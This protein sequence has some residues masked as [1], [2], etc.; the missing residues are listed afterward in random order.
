MTKSLKA[1]GAAAV[2][3]GSTIA[4]SA[5]ATAQEVSLSEILRLVEAD[6]TELS[7]TDRERVAQFQREVDAQTAEMET[8]R[9]ELRAAEAVGARLGNEFDNNEA[10]LSALSAELEQQAGD[11]GELLGQFRTAAGETMPIIDSSLA[12]FNYPGRTEQLSTVAQA[13]TLPTRADLD[14]LPKAMLREMIAQSEVKAF[15]TEVSGVGS[16]GE[17]AEVEVMRVGVFTAATTD[18][19]RFIETI[20]D[21]TDEPYLRVL[22]A[23]PAGKFRSAMNSLISA[24]EGD[25]IT[26]PFDPSKGDLFA[27]EGEKPTLQQRIGQGGA[28]GA[29]I[30]V[31]LA[32]GLVFALFKIV[33]LFLMGGAMRSTAKT[34]QAGDGNPLARVF[35]AYET[36][37]N[38]DLETLELKLD[39][40]ILR[41]SPKIE[42]FNDVVKVLAA[43]APLL[44]LLGTVIGMIITF[45]AI[46]NFGAGDPKLMAGG[47]STALMTTVLGLVAAIPLLLLHAVAA[48][49]ARGNQQVLDEQAAG[50]VAERAERSGASA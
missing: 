34:K 2:L 39:E 50:L 15:T 8:A 20:T 7:A 45:T 41:E 10:E 47:I 24:G 1:L 25:T 13:R 21:N 49:M 37:R 3:A 33:T 30:L 12:N 19:A 9:G 27:I 11:F 32:I 36:N 4:F 29:V 6:S 26:V 16:E 44:G 5:P 18:G 31:L 28:V 17:V 35:E 43:V 42:R 40:Q 38:A 23:Q 22:K 48:S 46:T 14:S